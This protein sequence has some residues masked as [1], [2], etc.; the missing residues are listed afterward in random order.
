MQQFAGIAF[1]HAAEIDVQVSAVANR[2]LAERSSLLLLEQATAGRA[3]RWF[4]S[5]CD[6]A[7]CRKRKLK[8]QVLS[9]LNGVLVLSCLSRLP[10]PATAR[11]L[12][13]RVRAVLSSSNQ[14]E[15]L[16]RLQ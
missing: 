4:W 6:V 13:H 10:M 16:R 9:T 15:Q 14:L 12:V 7:E 2:A 3:V 5:A 1:V 8:A 11:Q